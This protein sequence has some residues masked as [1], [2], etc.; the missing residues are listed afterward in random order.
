VART[1]T[2]CGHA[3][4]EAIDR[5]LVAG[6]SVRA[7]ARRYVPLSVTALQRHKA[8]H[9][10]AAMLQAQCAAEVAHA[11][12][13]LSQVRDLQRRALVILEKAEAANDLRTALQA[14]GQARANLELLARLLGE[15]QEAPVNILISP[16]WVTVRTVILSALG[17][18][19]EARVAVAAELGRL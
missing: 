12:G 6:E 18:F 19:P 10:P 7:L 3:D 5:A 1:C 14:I 15:L 17:S 8:S 11:D 16:E 2:V 13:L 4:R 9:L